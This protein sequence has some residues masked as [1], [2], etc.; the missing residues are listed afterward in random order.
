MCAARSSAQQR[1]VMLL[2]RDR[3]RSARARAD[4][5][6]GAGYTRCVALSGDAAEPAA[7]ALS[8]RSECAR[9]LG[10]PAAAV[11]DA[12]QALRRA[13]GHAK[14]RL[15][16]AAALEALERFAEAYEGTTKRRFRPTKQRRSHTLQLT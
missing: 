13:P 1:Q 11:D 7:T 14:A 15:R 9:Q 10:A 3:C 4:V 16:R 8:N 5:L 2:S 6:R 12:D